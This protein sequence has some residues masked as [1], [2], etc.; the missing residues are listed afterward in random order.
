MKSLS[1]SAGL[2]RNVRLYTLG[3]HKDS[4]WSSVCLQ[5][6][7]FLSER[8]GGITYSWSKTIQENLTFSR[9]TYIPLLSDILLLLWVTLSDPATGVSW[10]FQVSI[11][12]I[13]CWH[14]FHF[15]WLR[16]IFIDD[17]TGLPHGIQLAYSRWLYIETAKKGKLCQN[18]Q[19]CNMFN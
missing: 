7:C 16:L 3:H 13:Y 8:R 15:V 17:H 12:R 14:H 4:S 18:C 9:V 19:N 6:V 11:L 2:L 1:K 10:N 5:I